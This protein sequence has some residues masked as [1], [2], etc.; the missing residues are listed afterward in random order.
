M[1]KLANERIW[2]NHKIEITCVK[3]FTKCIMFEQRKFVDGK[4][5]A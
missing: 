1:V 4:S 2:S 3:K 5:T